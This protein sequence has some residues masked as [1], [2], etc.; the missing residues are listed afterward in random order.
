M[1]TEKYVQPANLVSTEHRRHTPTRHT[2]PP[3]T[4]RAL[5]HDTLSP[6]LSP[7]SGFSFALKPLPPLPSLR[8][9]HISSHAFPVLPP[10]WQNCIP[11]VSRLYPT[12]TTNLEKK[13][14]R[15][16][17]I[18]P[19]SGYGRGT[20]ELSRAVSRAADFICFGSPSQQQAG[21]RPEG[22][23]THTNHQHKITTLCIWQCVMWLECPL[24]S[25][26]CPFF[27]W[28]FLLLVLNI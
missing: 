15:E 18:T 27:M 17:E 26:L 11:C 24:S 6:A 21:W 23:V 2:W 20:R 9:A 1:L 8:A 19:A 14:K 7:L 3:A 22:E 25:L 5:S 10:K 4:S 12:N 16:S 13:K 28:V